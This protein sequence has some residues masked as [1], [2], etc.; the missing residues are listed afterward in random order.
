M[1]SVQG[2]RLVQGGGEAGLILPRQ[3]D[4][5]WEKVVEVS[6]GWMVWTP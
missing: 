5:L 4:V 2:I 1:V 6:S 3:A